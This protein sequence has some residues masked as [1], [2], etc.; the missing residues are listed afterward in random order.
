MLGETI[1]K[2]VFYENLV[3]Q[4]IRTI[5]EITQFLGVPFQQQML[6]HE[7]L[8]GSEIVVPKFVQPNKLQVASC[9]VIEVVLFQKRNKFRPGS[10]ADKHDCPEE[11][12]GASS[13]QSSDQYFELRSPLAGTELRFVQRPRLRGA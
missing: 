1:C 13:G 4:P 12:G 11:L 8:F 3:L 5:R 7:E 10:E 6:H 9:K 2:K